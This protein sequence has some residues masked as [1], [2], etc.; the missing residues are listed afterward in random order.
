MNLL[1]VSC[2]NLNKD[3]SNILE[4]AAHRNSTEWLFRKKSLSLQEHICD[5]VFIS[6]NNFSSEFFLI[7][8][9]PATVSN[10]LNTNSTKWSNKLK[11]L[12]CNLPTNF[13][14]LFDHF[15]GLALKGLKNNSYEALLSE[16]LVKAKQYE[17]ITILF[18]VNKIV[19]GSF[20]IV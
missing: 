7:E 12:D 10:I 19:R 3:M 2:G 9:L 11:Q 14:S 1:S 4:T 17:K 16:P 8:N 6:S 5:E 15:V 18:L 20:V 13:L